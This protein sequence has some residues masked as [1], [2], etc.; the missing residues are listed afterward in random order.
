[1]VWTIAFTRIK[2]WLQSPWHWAGLLVPVFLLGF[3]DL[4]VGKTA[5]ETRIPIVIADEDGSEYSR[6]VMERVSKNPAVLVRE[7]TR[8]EA[9]Q[10]IET[11]KAAVGFLLP[12]GFMKHIQ[13]NDTE[14]LVTM[15][16]SSG[17]ISHGLVR[18]IFASEVMRLS[19]NSY[20]A[21]TV[22]N[23]YGKKEDLSKQEQ[24]TVWKEA[25]AFSDK[26]WDPVPLM[27]I[28]YKV[29]AAREKAVK[30]GGRIASVYVPGMLFVLM[31]FSFLWNTWPIKDRQDGMNARVSFS[32]G[33]KGWMYWSGNALGVLILK[34]QLLV[35]LLVFGWWK[36]V[37]HLN[38]PTVLAL[39]GYILFLNALSLLIVSVIRSNRT[40]QAVTIFSVLTTTLLSGTFFPTDELSGFLEKAAQWTPQYWMVSSLIQETIWIPAGFIGI[41]IVLYGISTAKAGGSA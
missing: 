40:W 13:E 32:A 19:S 35:L 3:L 28:D 5:N 22:L 41:G 11:Q 27:S 1:M 39:L 18:E 20:G 34:L 29:G 33:G 30:A 15:W 10:Q 21:N 7:V 8:E 17:T 23:T 31:L 37:L 24:K 26:H 9:L 14:E 4:S 2:I 16:L 25:W 6:A 36:D 12:E 38:G